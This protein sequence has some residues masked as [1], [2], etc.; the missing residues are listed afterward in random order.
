MHAPLSRRL[1]LAVAG[2][3]LAAAACSSSSKTAAPTT[4]VAPTSTIARG[5][6][7]VNV[8][9]AGSLV[10]LMTK[11][12]GPGFGTATGYT[13]SGFSGDSGSLATDIKGKTQ[14]GDVF[15]SASP[16]VDTTLEGTAN[17][18]W[19]SWYATFATSPLVLGYD[20]SSKFAADLTTKAWY[21]VLAEPGILVGF[22]DPT[23]DPKGKLTA[24]ALN[25]AATANSEPALAT[26]ATTASDV[27]P[28]NTLVGRLQAGQLDVGFFYAAEA[29]AAGIMTV[30]LTGQ[31]EHAT[32]T[33]T[34]LNNAPHEAG[35]EAFVH[36]LLGAGALPAL[37]A[38]GFTLAAPVVSGVGVPTGLQNI[39]QG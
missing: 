11:Q 24:Q 1:V 18:N 33:I 16:T 15:V 36:Y 17:G 4:T 8:L 34:V 7:P 21:Q 9:Y 20:P 2:V 32:Y 22:T 25:G 6:G 39:L 3:A 26:L 29:K 28:E 38:D 23:T 13:F 30:P 5:S 14:V 10:S 37:T 31:S 19:V 35:A 12:V 27:Y